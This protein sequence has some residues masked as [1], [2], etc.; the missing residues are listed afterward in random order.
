MSGGYQNKAAVV[1]AP[2]GDGTTN[3]SVRFYDCT[4]TSQAHAVPSAWA[5]RI[6]RITNETANLAQF[7]FSFTSTA[8]CD[9]T[10]AAAANG[11]GS[12]SLGDSIAGNTELHVQLPSLPNPS[13]DTLYFVRASVTNT[14]LRM[15]LASP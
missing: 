7:F 3:T 2:F 4:S 15:R 10:I 11:G 8:S 6:V 9:E 13:A 1:L 14:S 5:G 12:A